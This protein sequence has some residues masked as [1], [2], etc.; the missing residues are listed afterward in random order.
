MN[1]HIRLHLPAIPY[2]ITRDEYSHCAF[3][4]KVKR[5][6][7]MMRSR[8]FEVYHYGVE[9]SESGANKDIQLMTKAEWNV[10]RIETIQWLNPKLTLEE[11]T[12]KNSDPTFTISELSNW[13][14]PLTKE[15]NKRLHVKLLESYRSNITDIICLPLAKTFQDAITGLNSVNVEIGI[16]YNTGPDLNFKIFESYSWLS[17]TAATEKKDPNNYWFVIPHFFDT[18]KF[19]LSLTPKPIRIGYLGRLTNLKGCGVIVE[20]A[21]KF[22]NL[23]FVLCGSGD[24]TPFLKSPNIVYKPPIHG[25]ERSEY[26]GSCVAFLHLAKYLEPFGC[27]PVEA[28]LCGTPVISTDW[29]GMTETIEQFKTGLRGHTLADYCYGVQM[30]LDGKFDRKYIRERAVNLYDMYKLAYNYEYVFNSVLDIYNGKNGWYSPD[31]HIKPLDEKKSIPFDIFLQ[32]NINANITNIK[33]GVLDKIYYINLNK[34]KDRNE[35]MIKEF[36][37]ARIENNIITRFEA[38]DGELYSF[39]DYELNLFK[40]ADFIKIDKLKPYMKKIMGNQLSHLNIYKDM[41]HNNYDKIL[42]LQDDVIFCDGFINH[43]NNICMSLPKDCEVLNIGLHEYANLSKFIKFNLNSVTEYMN[44][45]KEKINEYVCK[46]KTNT[47]PCSLAY[48]ITNKGAKNIISYFEKNG[49]KYAT[50]ISLNKY[51]IENDIFYGSRKILCTGE[52]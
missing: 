14:S 47:Q 29:G 48:I 26:L 23:E 41:I 17:K 30:A 11:A 3:T 18:N 8:G 10:L 49:F 28:Q 46:W 15:F 2:T 50:D 45:E 21:K 5:F 51:L 22:P 34:R 31:T 43:L 52:P 6:A 39:N 32:N 27:G 16:G 44:I 1:R 36:N 33:P 38:V 35:H 40:N 4:G 37:K 42:I 7:P 25:D 12:F 24:P 20:I 19:K 13:L 9:T